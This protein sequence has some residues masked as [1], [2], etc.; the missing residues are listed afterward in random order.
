MYNKHTIE[1][2]NRI[3]IAYKGKRKHFVTQNVPN[4]GYSYRENWKSL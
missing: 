2:E 4:Q 3:E 1:S